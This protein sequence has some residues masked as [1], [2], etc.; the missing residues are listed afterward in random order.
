[1]A[2]FS[3]T[4]FFNVI[5]KQYNEP[6]FQTIRS[7][8]ILFGYDGTDF[9]DYQYDNEEELKEDIEKLEKR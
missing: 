4:G 8:L 2:V 1:M 6:F 7:N 9:F 3:I 5:S